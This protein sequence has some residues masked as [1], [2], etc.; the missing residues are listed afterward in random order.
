MIAASQIQSLEWLKLLFQ[1]CI[2]LITLIFIQLIWIAPES[3]KE[4]V[5]STTYGTFIYGFLAFPQTLRYDFWQ[6]H[7]FQL[8]PAQTFKVHIAWQYIGLTWAWASNCSAG[9]I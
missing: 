4:E 6:I 3:K 2:E 8:L 9:H 7:F 1:V 5:L